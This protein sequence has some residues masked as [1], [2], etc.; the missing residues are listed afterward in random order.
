[1]RTEEELKAN[2]N[3]PF[4]N[5]ITQNLLGQWTFNEGAG[6]MVIDSSGNRNHA[7]YDKYAGGVELRRVQSRR[8]TIAHLL[9]ESEKYVDAGFLKLQKWKREFEQRNERPPTKADIMLADP[10]IMGL[11]R[12]LGEF[13]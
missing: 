12:R 4:S 6:D 10:E 3:K 7:S 9:T 1:M 5:P 2:M 8:P 13:S 11:A